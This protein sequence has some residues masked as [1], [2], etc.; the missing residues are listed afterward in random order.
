M[1]VL[2]TM[3]TLG[4]NA[5]AVSLTVAL[6]VLGISVGQQGET[7]SVLQSLIAAQAAAMESFPEG[8]LS[9][10][11]ENTADGRRA[12]V[13]NVWSGSSL[14][15]EATTWE[16]VNASETYEN[17]VFQ[18]HRASESLYLSPAAKRLQ[19]VQDGTIAGWKLLKLRPVDCWHKYSFPDPYT[20]R[21]I[22][23]QC[24]NA[25]PREFRV[26]VEHRPDGVIVVIREYLPQEVVSEIAFSMMK[27]GN[28]IWLN[29]GPRGAGAG[30]RRK[31]VY[32]W[33]DVGDGRWF[34]RRFES[35]ATSGEDVNF[36]HGQS[37]SI[38]ITDYDVAP[39]ISPERFLQSSLPL[40][41]GTLVEVIG[42]NPR[43]YRL[44][45]NG[46]PEIEISEERYEAM[47]EEIR[48]GRGFASGVERLK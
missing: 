43:R 29:S 41:V 45:L 34:L 24:L 5:T 3:L 38:S 47:A 1:Q 20:W 48:H 40:E 15:V 27:G 16:T 37:Y 28:V 13:Q 36:S 32:E 9:A 33:D 39:K 7:E 35:S 22:L 30:I 44:G 25:D 14:F 21:D 12:E 31:S 6:S 42:P 18:I 23:Q 10:I 19:I 17:Q 8:R 26:S 46:E 4:V 2:I 11:V